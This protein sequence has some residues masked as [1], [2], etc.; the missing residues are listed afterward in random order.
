MAKAA[1][2]F[3]YVHL[4]PAERLH[5][6]KIPADMLPY[7]LTFSKCSKFAHSQY[8]SSMRRVTPLRRYSHVGY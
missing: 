4:Q 6:Y 1:Y 3:S 7:I 5:A 2:P 8:K